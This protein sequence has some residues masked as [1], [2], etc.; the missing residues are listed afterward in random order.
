MFTIEIYFMDGLTG[1]QHQAGRV[2]NDGQ[3]VTIEDP[4]EFFDLS[5]PVPVVDACGRPPRH[6]VLHNEDP[7]LW[8]WNLPHWLRG[9]YVT[10][11]REKGSE[12][13][14]A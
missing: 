13:P 3:T 8:A 2:I 5:L 6:R 10:A 7:V 1:I 11:V 12:E 9:P 4:K 14:S